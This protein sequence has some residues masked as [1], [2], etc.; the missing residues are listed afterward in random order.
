MALLAESALTAVR[1]SCAFVI[2]L[3]QFSYVS[4]RVQKSRYVC[5]KS[6]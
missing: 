5:S 2:S 3:V 1:V 6:R 4:N